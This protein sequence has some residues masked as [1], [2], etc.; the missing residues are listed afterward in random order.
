M[1]RG[2]VLAREAL[3][4]TGSKLCL[5]VVKSIKVWQTGSGAG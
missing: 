3:G 2:C 4:T 5:E 1:R